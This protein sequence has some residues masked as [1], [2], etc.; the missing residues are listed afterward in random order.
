MIQMTIT[1]LGFIIF[2]LAA[3]LIYYITPH[4]FQWISLLFISVV[5]YCL[6]AEPYTIIFI[7]ISTLII[8]FSA[9]YAKKHSGSGRVA[10]S[11]T[12]AAI[13]LNAFIWFLF[14]GSAYW[15]QLSSFIHARVPAFP[16]M[17]G[18]PFAAAL[19]MG[20]YTCQAI[21]YTVD[22]YWGTAEPQDN[23]FKLFLFLIFF[24]QLT[25][26]PI[27][28]YNR[29]LPIY[30]GRVFDL[31]RMQRGMQR[32]L[33]GFFKKLV[34]SERIAILVNAID[35]NRSSFNGIWLLIALL[36]YPLQLYTD[37][38]GSVDIV[39]GTAEILGIELPENFDNPFFSQSSQEFWQKWH[40]SL[41]NWAKDYIM[42]PVLKAKKTLELSS[43][44]R[45]KY[46]KRAGKL[47]SLG[48]GVFFTWFVT[49]FWHGN[50]KYIVGC[51]MLY[52]VVMI[53]YEAFS[54]LLKRLNDLLGV[55]EDSFSWKLFRM[56]RTYIIFSFSLIFFRADGISEAIGMIRDL[57]LS[58]TPGIFNPWIFFNGE[59]LSAGLTDVDF[60]I[61][62]ISVI[63]LI[64]AAILRDKYGY[65]RNWVALQGRI[66]RWCVWLLLLTL[67]M[68]YGKYGP[69]YHAA[70]F[71]YQGF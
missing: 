26:G 56:I 51:G 7:V 31:Y 15:I 33:W 59:L 70:D 53:L 35:G 63:L 46:G 71:I 23:F 47:V 50:Y 40:M 68:V 60:H 16:A 29:L 9:L 39:L 13:V 19:G 41:G 36:F 34:I 10:F 3:S 67:V 44:V 49:G 43:G 54:P 64:L 18:L 28:H 38:S 69:G 11:I 30:E 4:R 5:F 62:W 12:I 25:T 6:A 45:K 2:V 58:F 14:K 8:Y 32:I 66:F 37:F 20:Y 65:A 21:G 24:P 55:K 27:S 1:S 42:Y 48:I 57:F 52:F 61:I 22:C 17:G